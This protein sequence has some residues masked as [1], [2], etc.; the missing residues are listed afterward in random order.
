MVDTFNT[1]QFRAGNSQAVRIPAKIAF[2]PKTEL[3][4]RREGDRIIVEP[5][6][7][8][9]GDVPKLFHALS[10]HFIGSRPDFEGTERDW[11]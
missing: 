11:L 7:R 1:R 5:K 6:E 10:Q 2:S 3:T 4:V 9:L 8:T